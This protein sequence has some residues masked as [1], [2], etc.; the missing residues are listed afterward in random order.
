MTTMGARRA[1]Q[2]ERSAGDFRHPVIVQQEIDTNDGSGG[3]NAVWSN[4]CT[5]Y[6]EIEH[7]TATETSGDRFPGRVRTEE[8]QTFRSW[9]RNDI[10]TQMRFL[11]DGD[12]WNIRHIED[13]NYRGKFLEIIAERGVEQ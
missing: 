13:V 8:L 9:W 11:Y 5:I 6:C 12:Y 1:M 10:N 2:A 3:Q 4:Y 7:T